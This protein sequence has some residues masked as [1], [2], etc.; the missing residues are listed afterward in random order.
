MHHGH[1]VARSMDNPRRVSHS[2]SHFPVPSP[3]TSR[4]CRDDV[5]VEMPSILSARTRA[6][7]FLPSSD[8]LLPMRALSLS[9]CVSL[10]CSISI[11]KYVGSI[12]RNP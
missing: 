9:L 3:I 7:S 10:V 12:F 8:I 1:C 5:S 11:R 4:L 6:P 2:F